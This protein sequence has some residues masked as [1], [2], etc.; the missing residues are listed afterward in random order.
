MVLSLILTAKERFECSE[1]SGVN[2][3]DIFTYDGGFGACDGLFVYW[4]VNLHIYKRF[5]E[6]LTFHVGKLLLLFIK[7]YKIMEE[8]YKNVPMGKR[9]I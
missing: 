9:T 7:K 5:G 4:V 2:N 6:T 3:F 8:E 1:L